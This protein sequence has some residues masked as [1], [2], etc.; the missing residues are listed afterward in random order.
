[1]LYTKSK[2]VLSESDFQNPGSCYRGAPFWS[3]NCLI[4]REMIDEQIGYFKE[5]GMGGFH[6]HVRV[7]LKNR[8]LDDEFME[9][10]RYCDRKAKENGLLCWLY[11]E[12]RYS[13]GIAGGEV[14]KTVAFRVRSLLLTTHKRDDITDSRE[15]F[16]EKQRKNVKTT[17]CLLKMYDIVLEDGC[18]K[19]FQM[20]ESLKSPENV[21]GRI[22]YLYEVMERE[23]P[24]CN[25]QTYVDTLNTDA[26]KDFI[27]KTHERYS[28]ALQEEFGKSIPAIFTDEPHISGMSLSERAVEMESIGLPFTE[29]LPELYRQKCGWDFFQAVPNMVWNWKGEEISQ[30]RYYLYEVCAEQFTSAYCGT[31]GKWCREHGILSTG[32][33]L[34][35]ES[36]AGQA[37]TVGEAMRCYREFQLPGIDNLCDLRE[38]SSVKQAS[39]VA[40]QQGREGVLSELYGVTQWDFDFEGYKLAGDWQAAL[41]VTTRVPHLAWASMAG[42]AKRDYPAAIGWQSPWYRDFRYIEDHFARVNYCLTRG[43]PMVH[44][45]MIHPIETMWVYQGAAGQVR[46]RSE[47]LETDFRNITEWLLTNGID[48]D[49]IAESALE[50]SGMSDDIARID[51]MDGFVCGKMKYDVILVPDCFHL[52]CNTFRRLSRFLENGGKV[53]LCGTKPKYAAYTEDAQLKAFT[54][55]CQWIPVEKSALLHVLEPWREI[56]I[57][58][59]DGGRKE[60]YLH[61]LRR[62]GKA[63]WL[64]LAQA[65]RGLQARQKGVWERRPLHAPEQ[66]V[67]HIKGCWLVEKYDTLTGKREKLDAG[68]QDGN[69]LLQYSLYGDDSLLLHLEPVKAVLKDRDVVEST[70]VYGVQNTDQKGKTDTG[71]GRKY[72][73]S[74]PT[75]YRTDEP[76]V[77]LL[78][79]FQYALEEEDYSEEC[80]LLK[81]DNVLRERLGCPLR[82]EQVEQPYV[83]KKSDN[84]EHR[85]RLRT[86]IHS[87][88]AADGCFLALEEPEYYRGTLNGEEIRME[89]VGYYV[90]RALR[91][92]ALPGLQEGENELVLYLQYGNAS[93]LEWMY[94]LGEFGVRLLGNYKEIVQ[95]PERLYWGDYTR[96]GYPFYT[97]NMVYSFEISCEKGTDLSIQIPYY[98]GAAVKISVDGE[99]EQMAALLPYQCILKKLEKGS[100]RIA[101]TCLGHRYNGFG[102]LHMMGNDLTWIGPD[103]WRTENE[104]WTEEYQV[105][106]MGV[107][108]APA[109]MELNSSV[110]ERHGY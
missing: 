94:L 20:L 8:Y 66:V 35:E 28:D 25:N 10:V 43:E 6:I 19:E 102:Q 57:K 67:I 78:D 109:I 3:W 52:R 88:I 7:G 33:I 27:A 21:R 60:F 32:H 40:H 13:S 101:V 104:S 87:R 92:V 17:G 45:G 98:A 75:G 95:K 26:V 69:T 38:F 18:L 36:L 11:D 4:T 63:R 100:H 82:M 22:W 37:G 46:G 83:R 70:C 84:R 1:M 58:G 39:S 49:Y 44:V 2:E 65:Y 85:V 55:R 64:F 89:P 41:G 103:S 68:Y 5:M 93:N 105:K 79:K 81:A 50:E 61:R 54:D 16:L 15:D 86:T 76:N 80:E 73:I 77:L 107:L 106:P 51:G 108:S 90:D 99:S 97:G 72:R 31:I 23:T 91:T 59:P 42:E 24:W 12:D 30:Q 74:R 62:E 34:G 29:K 96:Q 71:A 56:D 14:T 110:V 48:F 47:Q 9:L 53:I